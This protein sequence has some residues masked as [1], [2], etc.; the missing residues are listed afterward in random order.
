MLDSPSRRNSIALY[1]LCRALYTLT[2]VGIRHGVVPRVKNLSAIMFGVANAPIMFAFLLEPKYL[3][4]VR[5][6]TRA[7]RV[8][9]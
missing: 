5:T 4:P 8:C 3:E 9:L 1:C 6:E 2:R 7:A